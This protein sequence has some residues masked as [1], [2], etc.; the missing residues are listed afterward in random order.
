MEIN[1]LAF[2]LFQK[3]YILLYLA[4]HLPVLVFPVAIHTVGRDSGC[5][6]EE[7]RKV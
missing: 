5:R 1:H 6:D 2:R 3:R 4:H 7:L